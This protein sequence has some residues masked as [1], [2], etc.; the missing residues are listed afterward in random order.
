MAL[1]E[2]GRAPLRE[3]LL[4]NLHNSCMI[5]GYEQEIYTTGNGGA[6]CGVYAAVSA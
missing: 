1:Q 4:K 3:L 6:D 5:R 2:A